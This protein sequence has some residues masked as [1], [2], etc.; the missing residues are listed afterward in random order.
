MVFSIIVLG[1]G[2]FLFFY[3]NVYYFYN[4]LPEKYSEEPGPC[5]GLSLE[6]LLKTDCPIVQEIQEFYPPFIGFGSIGLI[7]SFLVQR[8][9]KINS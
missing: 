1:I 3:P 8:Q 5:Y 4:P 9:P 2:I 6:K 7:V